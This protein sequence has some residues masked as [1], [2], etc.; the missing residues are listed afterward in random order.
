MASRLSALGYNRARQLILVA[1]LIVL[2]VV[3]GLMYARRVETVD[4][5]GTLMFVL[6]FLAFGSKG[7]R[8]GSVGELVAALVYAAL[9]YP[10]SDLVMFGRFAS[11]IATRTLV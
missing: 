8:G 7:R 11:L 10:A 5:V 1:G 4:V 6:V 2:L 3:A 9:R